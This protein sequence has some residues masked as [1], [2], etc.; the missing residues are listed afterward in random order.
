MTRWIV[1][2]YPTANAAQHPDRQIE[3]HPEASVAEALHHTI[4]QRRPAVLVLN[5]GGEQATV[6]RVTPPEKPR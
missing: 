1:F 2:D 6:A 3:L 4:Q 5:A